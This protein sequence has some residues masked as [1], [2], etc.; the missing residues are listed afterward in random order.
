MQ[1]RVRLFAALR[2]RA[3]TDELALELPDGA[4]VRDALERMRDL[5]ERRPGGDGRQPGVR[6]RRI[7]AST[8]ATRSR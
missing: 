7:S 6:E 5:T 1:V 4:S 8:P 3:G 2:E